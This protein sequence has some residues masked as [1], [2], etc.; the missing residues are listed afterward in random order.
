MH[1]LTYLYDS[2]LNSSRKFLYLYT[3]N[4]VIILFP[5]FMSWYSSK[6]SANL[7]FIFLYV[8]FLYFYLYCNFF[9]TYFVKNRFVIKMIFYRSCIFSYQCGLFEVSTCKKS[10]KGESWIST[11]YRICLSSSSWLSLLFNEDKQY[12]FCG[13]NTVNFLFA[14]KSAIVNFNLD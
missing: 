10:W 5:L 6:T 4:Y 7:Y 9:C 14:Q 2:L 8:I 3:F 11:L 13:W 12:G 1:V